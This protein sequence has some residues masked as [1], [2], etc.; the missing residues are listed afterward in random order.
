MSRKVTASAKAKRMLKRISIPLIDSSTKFTF[1][2]IVIDTITIFQKNIT[3]MK[4]IKNKD[5]TDRFKTYKSRY[6]FHILPLIQ[7]GLKIYKLKKYDKLVLDTHISPEEAKELISIPKG[8][9][10]YCKNK[11]YI[12]LVG[13]GAIG[14]WIPIPKSD[15][16]FKTMYS[17][18][19][20][21]TMAEYMVKNKIKTNYKYEKKIYKSY[22]I[23][24]PKHLNT[25]LLL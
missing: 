19:G 21:K 6:P 4:P 20:N 17:R 13:A 8:F 14:N 22:K 2:T 11:N 3:P 10:I 18:T 25:K 23:S 7:S 9:N 15:K 12:R 5:G 24:K 16:V 1:P